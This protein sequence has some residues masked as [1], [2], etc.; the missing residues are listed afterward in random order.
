MT[1]FPDYTWTCSN[2]LSTLYSR[3]TK[4]ETFTFVTFTKFLLFRIQAAFGPRSLLSAGNPSSYRAAPILSFMLAAST[5]LGLLLILVFVARPSC[6]C[7]L[8]HVGSPSCCRIAPDF[9]SLLAVPPAVELLLLS[10]PC[11]Q[12]LLL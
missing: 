2:K 4:G 11:W 7:P 8:I 3:E 1:F 5:A 12:S 6:S 9:S 10:H